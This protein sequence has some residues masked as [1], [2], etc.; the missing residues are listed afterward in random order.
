MKNQNF[1][2]T[3]AQF[4]HIRGVFGTEKRTKLC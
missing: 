3:P 1:D 4:N 2:I